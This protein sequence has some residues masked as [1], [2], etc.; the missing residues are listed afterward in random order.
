MFRY[1]ESGGKR[2]SQILNYAQLGEVSEFQRFIYNEI[3]TDLK[4][5][6]PLFFPVILTQT[7]NFYGNSLYLS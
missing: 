6:F 3:V 1:L 7:D 5:G 4:F 2:R